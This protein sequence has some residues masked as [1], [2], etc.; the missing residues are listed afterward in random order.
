MLV[1]VN[2]RWWSVPVVAGTLPYLADDDAAGEG[3]VTGNRGAEGL[4]LGDHA[5]A[6]A[7]AGCRVMVASSIWNV[8]PGGVKLNERVLATVDIFVKVVG[9]E[10]N[11]TRQRLVGIV[12]LDR[13]ARCKKQQRCT[14]GER[15]ELHDGTCVWLSSSQVAAL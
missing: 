4:E 8:P 11:D 2:L 15:G 3:R 12:C 14:H 9:G 6:V 7:A 5:L 10:I 1:G 13:H